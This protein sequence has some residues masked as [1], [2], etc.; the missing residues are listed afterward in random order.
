MFVL[1]RCFFLWIL[2]TYLARLICIDTS[3][4][5]I[6]TDMPVQASTTSMH[7]MIIIPPRRIIF[8]IKYEK[9]KETKVG[10]LRL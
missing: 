9:R 4:G 1:F 6:D 10:V 7:E 2:T 3:D 5:L 8:A